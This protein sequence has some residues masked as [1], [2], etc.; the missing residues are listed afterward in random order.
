MGERIVWP[1]HSLTHKWQWITTSLFTAECCLY[2]PLF[3]ILREPT[4]HMSQALQ[5]GFGMPTAG[6]T[7]ALTLEA[8]KLDLPPHPLER[9]KELL[10]LLNVTAQILLAMNDKQRRMH[11]LHIFDRRH[12]HILI[13]VLPGRRLQIIFGQIPANIA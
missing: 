7:M 2:S 5:A 3:Q 11:I 9:T 1:D 6:E 13:Q 8:H 4:L 10:S 12:M